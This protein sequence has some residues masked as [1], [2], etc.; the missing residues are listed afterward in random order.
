MDSSQVNVSLDSGVATLSGI[1]DTM[2]ERAS[3]RNNAFEGGA[4]AVENN[5]EVKQ[6]PKPLMHMN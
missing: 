4:I 2:D 1:V 3:A 6:G 5:L